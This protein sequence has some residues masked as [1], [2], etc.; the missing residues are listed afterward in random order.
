MKY[1]AEYRKK[2]KSV[3]SHSMMLQKQ[4]LRKFWLSFPS[5][6]IHEN[7]IPLPLAPPSPPHCS[8]WI[9][10]IHNNNIECKQASCGILMIE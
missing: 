1:D 3:S 7:G 5:P 6:A 10:K 4:N 8:D 9:W 2:Q